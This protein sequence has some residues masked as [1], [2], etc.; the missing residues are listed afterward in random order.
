MW[1]LCGAAYVDHI[2]IYQTVQFHN[3]FTWNYFLNCEYFTIVQLYLGLSSKQDLFMYCLTAGRLMRI[4]Y[5]DK[6][7]EFSV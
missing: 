2:I 7:F 4:Q 6:N 5:L 3:I 1:R